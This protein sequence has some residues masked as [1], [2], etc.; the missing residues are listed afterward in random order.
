M[1]SENKLNQV[2]FKIETLERYQDATTVQNT[3]KEIKTLLREFI[4]DN[5]GS[6]KKSFD[7][8]NYT[9]KKDSTMGRLHPRLTGVCYDTINKCAVSTDARMII[10]DRATYDPT[11]EERFAD[12][13]DKNGCV[14]IDK[15]G[16]YIEGD[17]PIYSSVFPNG[18]EAQQATD[19]KIDIDALSDYIKRCKSYL[20]VN[21]MSSACYLKFY[22]VGPAYYNADLLLSFAIATDGNIS[23]I[24]AGKA[25]FW[26]DDNRKSLIMP[27]LA[28]DHLKHAHGYDE[29]LIILNNY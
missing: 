7:M 23:I 5:T 16:N 28:P 4:I 18:K 19:Y 29:G 22:K 1:K 26:Y 17:Y 21:N 13:L 27:M 10:I 6:P 12:K 24:D 14:S 2:I 8:F 15:Y 25:A 20:K 11:I 9:A 3:A